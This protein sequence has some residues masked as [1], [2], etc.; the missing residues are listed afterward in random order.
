VIAL[1][2]FKENRNPDGTV[3]AQRSAVVAR[4]SR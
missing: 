1:G 3:A 4:G 2:I